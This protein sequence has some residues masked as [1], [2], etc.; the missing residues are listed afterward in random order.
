M[1]P[2]LPQPVKTSHILLSY[3]LS[4]RGL[5]TFFRSGTYDTALQKLLQ[6]PE[7]HIL[8]VYGN[9]DQFTAVQKY[10]KWVLDL[11]KNNKANLTTLKIDGGD[12][13]WGSAAS[14]ELCEAV[15]NWLSD[16]TTP[17]SVPES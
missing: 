17:R 4:V 3:P 13:F 5:I 8:I 14:N 15:A 6:E 1:H 2:L 16:E 9:Q 12:H 10:D 7:A 11:K